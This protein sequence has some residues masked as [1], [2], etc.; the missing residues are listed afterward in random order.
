MKK[1][2]KILT[3]INIFILI[4]SIITVI[5]LKLPLWLGLFVAII[6]MTITLI[7]YEYTYKQMTSKSLENIKLVSRVLILLSLISLL[8][9]LLIEIGCLPNFI[10]YSIEKISSF[11]IVLFSFLLSLVL[12]M[13]LGTAIGTLTIL[14]PL[15]LSISY[16]LSI[17]VEFIV[18]ALVSGSYFGDRT[19]PLSSSAHLTALVTKTSVKKNIHLMIIS[20][21]IPFIISVLLYNWLGKPFIVNDSANIEGLKLALSKIYIISPMYILPIFLLIGLITF[22]IPIIHSIVIVYAVSFLI[23]LTQGFDI[24]HYITISINGFSTENIYLNNILKSSGFF[25]MFD[26]LLVII[27]SAVLNS[28]FELSGMLDDIIKPFLKN[29]KTYSQLTHKAAILSIVLSILTCNQTL[30]SII[31]GKYLNNYYD[32]LDVKRNYLAKTIGDT[33]LNIVGIIPWNVNGLLVATLTGVP[34]IIYFKYAFFT[35][36]LPLFSTII[37]PI[38]YNRIAE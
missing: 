4:I 24:A 28:L 5:L 38:I 23:Y 15:F 32:D 35:L 36:L 16:N 37:H 9:P 30:T 14:V 33:G 20:S 25:Q 27:A 13:I 11:N 1:I 7:K 31:T 34:T 17:P 29:I 6:S 26:V 8:I 19:S 22:R 2:P 21:I 10:F 18:G 3:L 12:S